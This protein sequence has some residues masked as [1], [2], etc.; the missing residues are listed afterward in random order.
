MEAMSLDESDVEGCL[1]NISNSNIITP[2]NLFRSWYF[3]NM[4]V[5]SREIRLISHCI[6]YSTV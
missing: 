6:S 4:P 5:V 2:E 3:Q 1:I